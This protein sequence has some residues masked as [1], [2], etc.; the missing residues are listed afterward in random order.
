M[1]HR[2]FCGLK[3][4]GQS[5]SYLPTGTSKG[6]QRQRPRTCGSPRRWGGWYH[7]SYAYNLQSISPKLSSWSCIASGS[8]TSQLPAC[9]C[10]TNRVRL[11]NLFAS[12]NI[13][14]S[15][16]FEPKRMNTSDGSASSLLASLL[17][18]LLSLFFVFLCFSRPFFLFLLIAPWNFDM[19][20]PFLA[21][22]LNLRKALVSTTK[23][24]ILA[25]QG[26][27]GFTSTS[28]WSRVLVRRGTERFDF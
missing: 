2:S 24:L 6:L 22:V 11:L 25:S 8:W 9:L 20:S 14:V 16:N 7:G 27:S 13:K 3:S 28:A 19:K 23:P 1:S 10:P 26:I 17:S 15:W 5:R 12:G 18:S 21:Q 4:P